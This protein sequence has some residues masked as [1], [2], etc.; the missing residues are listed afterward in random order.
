M[1]LLQY[2]L[3]YHFVYEVPILCIEGVVNWGGRVEAS[4]I[5]VRGRRRDKKRERK[6]GG[7]RGRCLTWK[8]EGVVDSGEEMRVGGGVGCLPFQQFYHAL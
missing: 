4:N 7:E 1:A 6:E 3:L 5:T 8:K 2:N